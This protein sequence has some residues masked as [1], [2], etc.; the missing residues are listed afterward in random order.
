MIP[1]DADMGE[2]RDSSQL[3]QVF[4][5]RNDQAAASKRTHWEIPITGSWMIGVNDSRGA[6]KSKHSQRFIIY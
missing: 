6:A 5:R 4:S 1:T 2:E 3:L